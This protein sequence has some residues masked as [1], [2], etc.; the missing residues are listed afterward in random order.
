MPGLE[1]GQILLNSSM[2]DLGFNSIDRAEVIVE[3]MADLRLQ[4][5]LVK[6]ASAKNIEEVIS[7]FHEHMD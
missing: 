3:T 1:A 6:F 7:I 5:P 2:R 4:V